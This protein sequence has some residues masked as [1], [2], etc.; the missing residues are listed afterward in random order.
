MG[1]EPNFN[2]FVKHLLDIFDEI[3][4]V[5]KKEGT[6]WVNFGDTYA[7]NGGVK[8]TNKYTLQCKSGV[9]K[10]KAKVLV[11]N[12]CMGMTPSC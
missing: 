6:C 12:K 5:L 8:A 1:L 3:K 10:S 2:L 11:P 9:L 7:N 4:R